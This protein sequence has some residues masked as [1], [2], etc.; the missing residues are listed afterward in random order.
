MEPNPYEASKTEAAAP[1]AGTSGLLIAVGAAAMLCALFFQNVTLA[2]NSY[3]EVLVVSLILTVF[4]DACLAAVA[5]RGPTGSRLL[6]LAAMM[7]TLFILADFLRR[8]PYMF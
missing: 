4:A 1:S 7:P 3:R 6:A 2:G 8:A 5:W